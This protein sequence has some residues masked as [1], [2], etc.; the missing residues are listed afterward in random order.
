M[1]IIMVIKS[2]WEVHLHTGHSVYFPLSPLNRLS[3]FEGLI[4]RLHSHEH[5]DTVH[6]KCTVKHNHSPDKKMWQL[7]RL[8]YIE[9]WTFW[10][11]QRSNKDNVRQWVMD[12][13]WWVAKLLVPSLYLQPG[14]S[15]FHSADYFQWCL[16]SGP[17]FPSYVHDVGGS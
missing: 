11:A 13:L 3:F 17:T 10:A 14:C 7:D 9:R 16:V 4:L 1:Y 8:L 2:Q 5:K 6:I 15:P 12:I